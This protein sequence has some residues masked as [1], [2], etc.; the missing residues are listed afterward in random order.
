MKINNRDLGLVTFGS[1]AC[2]DVF[3]HHDDNTRELYM[4]MD[5]IEDSDYNQWNVVRLADGKVDEFM[6]KASVI[7]VNG[8]YEI[9]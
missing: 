8:E 2:G 6:E 3:Y 9:D 4:K 1:L 5:T 7:L